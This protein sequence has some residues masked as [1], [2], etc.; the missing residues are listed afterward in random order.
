M[1]PPQKCLSQSDCLPAQKEEGREGKE[2]WNK[3]ETKHHD[4]IIPPTSVPNQKNSF[5]IQELLGL[6]DHHS[7]EA[8]KGQRVLE[9]ENC[10]K[11]IK[12]GHSDASFLYNQIQQNN[13]R[14]YLNSGFLGAA[15]NSFFP[16][17]PTGLPHFMSLS[18]PD[19]GKEYVV[20]AFVFVSH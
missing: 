19:K 15:A 4:T 10:K 12:S 20:R 18:T 11:S 16:H 13:Q 14:F 9:M 5:G 2:L 7:D 3:M 1:T 8:D 6:E 17:G